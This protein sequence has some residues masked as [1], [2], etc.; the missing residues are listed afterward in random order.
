MFF[1]YP[2]FPKQLEEQTSLSLALGENGGSTGDM[3]YQV[4]TL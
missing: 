2:K 3:S 4:E 1:G